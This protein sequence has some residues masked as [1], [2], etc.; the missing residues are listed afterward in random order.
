MSPLAMQAKQLIERTWLAGPAYDLA[1][2]AAFALESAQMLQSPET[3]EERAAAEDA[4][5]VAGEALAELKREHEEN[6]RLRAR[7]AELEARDAALL[8]VMERVRN[9][10]ASVADANGH[11]T[12]SGCSVWGLLSDLA[13]VRGLN[14]APVHN[15]WAGERQEL[16]AI[17]RQI[18]PTQALRDVPDGEHYAAVHHDYHKG[19]DLPELG[20]GQ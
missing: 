16:D 19:R 7:V 1:S 5:R 11:P 9:M 15:Q 18:A 14:R 20:G 6:T 8:V 17:T 13:T 4:V 3:A 12:K 2:Q 10:D